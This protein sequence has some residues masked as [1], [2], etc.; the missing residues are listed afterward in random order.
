M[1]QVALFDGGDKPAPFFGRLDGKQSLKEK[2]LR[3]S[4]V[5]LQRR[6]G[7]KRVSKT[8]DH[9]FPN[10]AVVGK[11]AF[12]AGTRRPLSALENDLLLNPIEVDVESFSRKVIVKRGDPRSPFGF[13]TPFQPLDDF[14][15]GGYRQGSRVGDVNIGCA[16]NFAYGLRGNVDGF[17]V[18]VRVA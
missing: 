13:R 8:L 7:E 16:P 12:I 10:C 4:G 5:G 3:A 11:N 15:A 9:V 18:P 6:G 1:H 17:P 14:H 2:Q